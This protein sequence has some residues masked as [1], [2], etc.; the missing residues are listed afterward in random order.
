MDI[1]TRKMAFVERFLNINDEDLIKRL[2]LMINT[3]KIKNYE[4]YLKP[5]TMEEFYKMIDRAV[6]DHENGNVISHETLVEKIKTW[7]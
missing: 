7:K 3:E 5:M 4:S 1:R 6:D 2:E